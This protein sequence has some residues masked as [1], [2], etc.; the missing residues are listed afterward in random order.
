MCNINIRKCGIL[1]I[2]TVEKN[3]KKYRN[4]KKAASPVVTG[5]ESHKK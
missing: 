4:L 1:F 3:R 5:I 2:I